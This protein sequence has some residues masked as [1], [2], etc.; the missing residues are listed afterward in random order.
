MNYLGKAGV[1][2][3]TTDPTAITKYPGL[4]TSVF[5]ALWAALQNGTVSNFATASTMT[6][7]QPPRAVEEHRAVL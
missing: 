5:Y 2:R 3:F 7:V 6:Q 4:A 1:I